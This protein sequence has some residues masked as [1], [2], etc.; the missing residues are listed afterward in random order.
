MA[1]YTH[2]FI[3]YI[4][5]YIWITLEISFGGKTECYFELKMT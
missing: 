4:Y 3:V 5:F 1:Y 2:T